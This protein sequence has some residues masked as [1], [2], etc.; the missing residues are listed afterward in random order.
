[1][2]QVRALLDEQ[3]SHRRREVHLNTKA[4]WM[5]LA[6]PSF[7]DGDPAVSDGQLLR[8]F[9]EGRDERA[10][11]LLLR[12]HAS[13]VMGVCRR[14][15]SNPCDADDAFQA[16]F[17]I[18]VRKMD[19]LRNREVFGNW[20]HGV[21][22]RVAL[23]AKVQSIRRQ[24]KERVTAK[25]NIAPKEPD[26]SMG[27]VLDEEI[28]RLPE[29]YRKPL[30]LCDLQG[31]TRKEAARDLG[32]LEGTVAGRLARA[33]QRLAQRLNA[34]GVTLP[35]ISITLTAGQVATVEA[36]Q[37]AL[38]MATAQAASK[39]LASGHMQGISPH[40]SLLVSGGM[41]AMR[42]SNAKLTMFLALCLTPIAVAL[43]FGLDQV[44][45]QEKKQTEANGISPEKAQLQKLQGKWVLQTVEHGNTRAK[46]FN[47]EWTIKGDRLELNWL[48]FGE[49]QGAPHQHVLL[50]PIMVEPKDR[51]AGPLALDFIIEAEVAAS[52]SEP[53]KKTH[54]T[55]PGIYALEQTR[56]KVAI[57]G[58]WSK[59]TSRP[60]QFR[61]DG[62]DSILILTFERPEL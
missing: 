17:L 45:L 43:G 28:Q 5:R 55:V 2:K 24:I 49:G 47:C 51:S 39:F 11:H 4:L 3:T 23:K 15:L 59:I 20:L 1:M 35:T 22:F 37:C 13:M 58:G 62:D 6:L 29:I 19:E 57:R 54:K 48:L 41:T 16:T 7:S 33:R 61:T 56:L 10:F 18:L 60:T 25:E 8:R 9:V 30:I 32:W 38:V 46:M 50:K 36:Q 12:R 53:S 40:I 14:T 31:R 34:R 21:A 42:F 44:L 52:G 27:R 26:L